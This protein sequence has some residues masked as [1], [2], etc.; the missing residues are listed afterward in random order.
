MAFDAGMKLCS[1]HINCFRVFIFN[2][3]YQLNGV[4]FVKSHFMNKTIWLF[5]SMLTLLLV[6]CKNTKNPSMETSHQFTNDLINETS[7]YLLQ[8]AHNPVDW[9]PWNDETLAL[10]KKE[11]KLILQSTTEANKKEEII[12]LLE[13]QKNSLTSAHEQYVNTTVTTINTLKQMLVDTLDANYNKSQSM[14]QTMVISVQKI[15]NELKNLVIKNQET[16][17]STSTTN[18]TI[19]QLQNTLIQKIQ[20]YSSTNKDQDEALLHRLFDE[21][22]QILTD[23]VAQQQQQQQSI[24]FNLIKQTMIDVIREQQQSSTPFSNSVNVE[25]QPQ[26]KNDMSTNPESQ[27]KPINGNPVSDGLDSSL[28]RTK[29]NHDSGRRNS[30]SSKIALGRTEDQHLLKIA[31]KSPESAHVFANLI[32]DGTKYSRCREVCLPSLVL[33]LFSWHLHTSSSPSS[34]RCSWL[35]SLAQSTEFYYS[36]CSCLSL[37]L[38]PSLNGRR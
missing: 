21:Q 31:I 13:E 30:S 37:D 34:K 5:A 16:L 36:Q 9:H 10:A 27:H 8:H 1:R 7:P 26:S 22:K 17:E 4:I 15:E 38:V 25:C 19:N 24:S 18:N 2:V 11:N 35:S 23:T 33:W 3:Q 32:L 20:N 14:E 28:P 12:R 29:P 6:S